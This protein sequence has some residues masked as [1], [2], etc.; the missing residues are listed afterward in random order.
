MPQSTASSSTPTP[1]STPKRTRK[2]P[3]PDLKV[4]DIIFLQVRLCVLV[5]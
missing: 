5:A 4:G 3:A 1:N 2:Y